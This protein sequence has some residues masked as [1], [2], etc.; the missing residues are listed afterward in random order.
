MNVI[1]IRLPPLRE[2]V[3]RREAAGARLPEEVRAG[4]DR[5][6]RGRGDGGARGL[7]L[8]RQCPRAAECHR[9]ARAR[10][11]R[12]R[13]SRAETCRT[14]CWSLWRRRLGRVPSGPDLGGPDAGA[15][16]PLKD[17]KARWME[18]LEGTY[19]RDLLG[20]SRRQHLRR[21][22]GRGHRP[23]DVPPPRQQIPDSFLTFPALRPARRA[24]GARV[25]PRSGRP[26]P[27]LL[28][29]SKH[30]VFTVLCAGTRVANRS[31]Q[32][33]KSRPREARQWR[34][35]RSSFRWTVRSSPSTRSGRP[36]SSRQRRRDRDARPRLPRPLA[37]PASIPRTCRSTSSVRRKSTSR[38]SRLDSSGT[39]PRTYRRA[40]GTDRRCR[41]SSRRRSMREQTSSS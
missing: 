12:T 29:S 4:T 24:R 37:S 1:A 22:E 17:A 35:R 27:A 32:R 30:L 28:D 14:M 16:L 2:R 25:P 5:G 26:T 21:R 9:S 10:L 13:P 38:A 34:S 20:A 40:C 15:D 7:S 19:L 33:L 36:R 11:P 3:G 6:D 39:E 41:P 8:A 23:Q 18:V 31:R